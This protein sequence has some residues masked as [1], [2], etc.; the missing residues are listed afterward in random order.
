[1]KQKLTRAMCKLIKGLYLNIDEDENSGNIGWTI[2]E[3]TIP[4]F[5][6]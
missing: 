3:K 4:A 2:S 6:L 1:M 5:D